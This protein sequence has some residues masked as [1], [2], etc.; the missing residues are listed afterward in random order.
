MNNPVSLPS[1]ILGRKL[2]PFLTPCNNLISHTIRPTDLLHPSP[3]SPS[4]TF[5]EMLIYFPKCQI[6]ITVSSYARNGGFP[7]FIA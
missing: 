1:F 7:Y 3:A 6:F 2:L 4:R 5:K